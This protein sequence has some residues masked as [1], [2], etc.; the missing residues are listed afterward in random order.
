MF[1]FRAAREESRYCLLLLFNERLF[2]AIAS[3]THTESGADR[4]EAYLTTPKVHCAKTFREEGFI[5]YFRE[6]PL[7]SRFVSGCPAN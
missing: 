1:S 5:A 3:F 2:I 6:Y 4:V 7:K